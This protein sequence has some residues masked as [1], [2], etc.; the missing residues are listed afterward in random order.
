MFSF[1]LPPY[2]ERNMDL[3]FWT[4]FCMKFCFLSC[5]LRPARSDIILILASQCNLLRITC[6]LTPQDTVYCFNVYLP[7]LSARYTLLSIH[8]CDNEYRILHII[9]LSFAITCVARVY[10]NREVLYDNMAP[11]GLPIWR[12]TRFF[13]VPSLT[14]RGTIISS[15]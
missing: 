5:L 12:F 9:C 11:N 10:F 1:R 13:S 4:Y 2:H 6:H 3:F 15:Y 14:Y 8:K 7:F